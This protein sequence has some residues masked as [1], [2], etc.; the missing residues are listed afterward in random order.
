MPPM[1]APIQVIIIPITKKNQD[2][3]S[4]IDFANMI[5]K[6]LKEEGLRVFI[7]NNDIHSLGYKINE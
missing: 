3:K 4:V 1:I 7:D 6:K 5:E 2:N